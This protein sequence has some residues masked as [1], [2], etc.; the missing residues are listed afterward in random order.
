MIDHAGC[1]C[2]IVRQIGFI[3]I[4][5]VYLSFLDITL[6]RNCFPLA[7]YVSSIGRDLN[8]IPLNRKCFPLALYVSSIGRHL[9]LFIHHGCKFQDR[10]NIV[11]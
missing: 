8:T 10:P 11:R 5:D 3:R 1:N 9:N 2:K 6:K 7:L 4:H